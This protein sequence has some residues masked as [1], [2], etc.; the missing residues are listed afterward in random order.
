ML[1]AYCGIV[2]ARFFGGGPFSFRPLQTSDAVKVCLTNESSFSPAQSA[3]GLYIRGLTLKIHQIALAGALLIPFAVSNANAETYGAL[4]AGFNDA[5]ASIGGGSISFDQGSTY[6]GA[7]GYDAGHLRFEAGVSRDNAELGIVGIDATMTNFSATA[8]ADFNGP[9]GLTYF[10]GAGLDYSKAEANLGFFTAE[11]E[12]DGWHYDLGVSKNISDRMTLEVRR[13][14][15]DGSVDFG[16]GTDIDVEN[17]AWT[18]GVRV[19]L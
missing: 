6:E 18:A 12:G 3:H 5:D 4:R 9:F 13:R 8:L 11:G 19:S 15:Y 16:F 17:T 2:T 7:I 14:A 10:A 1:A